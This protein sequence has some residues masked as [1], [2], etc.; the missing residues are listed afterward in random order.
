MKNALRNLL[1]L[2]LLLFVLAQCSSDNSGPSFEKRR[3]GLPDV[4]YNGGETTDFGSN[5]DV[6]SGG[7]PEDHSEA[8]EYL[9]AHPDEIASKIEGT[10]EAPLLWDDRVEEEIDHVD[11]SLTLTL[12]VDELMIP[13]DTSAT[14]RG[15]VNCS[16]TPWVRAL[17]QIST[18][19]GRLEGSFYAQLHPSFEGDEWYLLSSPDLRNFKG[20]APLAIETQRP[21]WAELVAD[22]TLRDNLGGEFEGFATYTD[23]EFLDLAHVLP[24]A[25]WG[26]RIESIQNAEQP[27]TLW[28]PQTKTITLDEY[29]GSSETPTLPVEIQVTADDENLQ[30]TTV[31][32]R[33]T[34]DGKE[35]FYEDLIS[36]QTI[37]LGK[38]PRGTKVVAE[39]LNTHD[40]AEISVQIY[41][42]NVCNNVRA[43]CAESNCK[44]RIETQVEPLFCIEY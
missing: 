23:G 35:E 11:D 18:K 19:S 37:D 14:E 27:S 10:R 21:H 12:W 41:I 38:L 7:D 3:G 17:A 2:V 1:T 40:N 39:A 16:Q 22:I 28:S 44:A 30:S 29:E 20:S 15:R 31:D 33:V 4:A 26:S 5:C 36:L 32:L 6:S 34:I 43:S 25:Y 42:L 13:E 9:K 8:L 24:R